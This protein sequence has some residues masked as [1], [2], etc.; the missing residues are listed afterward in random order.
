M[1]FKST[2]LEKL[3]LKSIKMVLSML[4]RGNCARENYLIYNLKINDTDVIL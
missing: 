1:H 2:F 4:L 3:N